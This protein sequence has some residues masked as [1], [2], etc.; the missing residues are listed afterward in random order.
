MFCCWHAPHNSC[1]Q[2]C[3]PSQSSDEVCQY[4]NI[5]Y[6][7]QCWAIT[8]PDS[9]TDD[10]IWYKPKPGCFCLG[11]LCHHVLSEG[12]LSGCTISGCNLSGC[13]VGNRTDIRCYD[14]RKGWNVWADRCPGKERCPYSQLQGAT[15]TLV[16]RIRQLIHYPDRCQSDILPTGTN[17]HLDICPCLDKWHPDKCR[18]DIGQ[19]ALM[20]LGYCLDIFSSW[21]HCLLFWSDDIMLLLVIV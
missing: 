13:L 4:A 17:G 7:Y 20:Y 11:A 14:I 5:T 16:Y 10:D 9:G 3:S 2:G 21:C 6:S 15:T 12:T 8:S 1:G 18:P 19:C